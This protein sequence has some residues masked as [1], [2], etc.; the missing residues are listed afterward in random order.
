MRKEREEHAM[1]QTY[2][3]SDL[4]SKK[5]TEWIFHLRLT[6]RSKVKNFEPGDR[7]KAQ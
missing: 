7:E 4:F 1:E 6:D 2:K 5:G 3:S